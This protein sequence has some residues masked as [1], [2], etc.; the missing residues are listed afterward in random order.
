MAEPVVVVL[1]PSLVG[2]VE[3][4]DEVIQVGAPPISQYFPY[5]R[6]SQWANFAS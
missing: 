6:G 3:S 1:G 5:G 2:W 4:Q